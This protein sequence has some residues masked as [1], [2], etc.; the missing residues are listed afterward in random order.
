MGE[1]P[2]LSADRPMDFNVTEYAKFSDLSNST[3]YF[4]EINT[5]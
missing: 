5:C 3:I 4:E 1:R 2:I